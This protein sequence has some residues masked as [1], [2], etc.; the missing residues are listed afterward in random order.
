VGV[1]SY[2]GELRSVNPGKLHHAWIVTR[3]SIRVEQSGDRVQAGPGD[4]VLFEMPYPG[5]VALA[6]S[7][8]LATWISVPRIS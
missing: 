6:S 4:V 8:F 3:G 2:D 7:D 1:W 5:K